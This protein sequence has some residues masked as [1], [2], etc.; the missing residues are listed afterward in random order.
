MAATDAPTRQA[1]PG[2]RPGRPPEE[3]PEPEPV[4]EEPTPETQPGEEAEEPEEEEGEPKPPDLNELLNSADP[5][6]LR[7]HPRLAGIIGEQAKREANRL[8]EQRADEILRDREL[9][10]RAEQSR[11]DVLAKARTGDYYSI[12]EQAA[13][14]AL[15]QDQDAAVQQFERRAESNTYRTVQSALEDWASAQPPEVNERAAE[16]MGELAE[17][18]PWVDGFRKWL[19]AYVQ[20]RAEHLAAQPE[21]KQRAEREA[22]PA[23]KARV[24]AEMNGKEP[25]ADSGSGRAQR[26]RKVTDE[27]IARMDLD[28]Y[29]SIWDVEKGRPK[30]GVIYTPT[31]AVDPRGMRM[32]GRGV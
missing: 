30:P 27:D 24:L 9:R 29:M 13:R 17:G 25:T 2:N 31:R 28:E 19:D 1:A 12:G 21:T 3:Q 32:L 14:D 15:K 4:E 26:T 11:Q 18:T 5:A 7:K 22:I 8:A 16:R 10:W 20:V 6:T 23:V